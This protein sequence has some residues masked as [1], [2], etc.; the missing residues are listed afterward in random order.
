MFGFIKNASIKL[1]VLS[2]FTVVFAATSGLG[3]VSENR[4]GAVNAESVEIR[5][6]Y[7]PSTQML[8]KLAYTAMQFRQRE[9][10]QLLAEG[11]EAKATEAKKQAESLA[12]YEALM[13]AY[14]PTIGDG[15]ERRLVDSFSRKWRDYIAL[16]GKL[17][18]LEEAQDD[19][20]ATAL[21]FGEQRTL[22]NQYYEDL[23]ADL[24]F[25]E[26]MGS[27]AARRA[28][29]VYLTTRTIIWSALALAALLCVAAGWSII[30]GVSRPIGRMTEV[31][32]KLAAHDL[33]VA[34]E[35]RGGKNEIGRMAE[36]VQ[37]FKDTMIEGD[38]LAAE[39][40]AEQEAKMRRAA[41][42]D[43]MTR[44]FEEKVG[45]MVGALAA[46]ATEM[47]ASAGSMTTVAERT[48]EQSVSVAAA[49]EQTSAN[50]QT[51]ATATEEL[52]ASIQEISRQVATSARV[53][54]QA[55]KAAQETDATVQTL[56]NGAQKV[57]DVVKLIS[58]IASQTNLLALNATI[59]AARAGEAGKGFAV[60]ASEV[61]GLAQQT[62]KATE[63][64]TQQISG[65]QEATRQ[66][67]EAIRGIGGTIT[68]INEIASAIASAVEEQG[69]ATQEIAR[70]VQQAAQ[71]TEV[72][73][74]NIVNL[75]GSATDTGAAATQ[76]KGA[77]GELSQHSAQLKLEV[78]SFLAE[79][80]AA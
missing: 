30:A 4:L 72:V 57:G 49:S 2:A 17:R 64:I 8:G 22:F 9:A 37:V 38:R 75:K 42:V 5:T 67:V 31:M 45:H 1:Q 47:E 55:V 6:N 21:Y 52:S 14:E 48:N 43:A 20:A 19:V 29:Q 12:D 33:T 80:K 35:G 65:I 26:K 74:S 59:E 10:T 24:D 76:V 15:E 46:A 60:V 27:E 40:A 58:D 32:K 11:T 56:A 13:R 51:V 71:A 18:K 7:L 25:N 63:E 69:A 34:V 16:N 50:V 62:A 39:Q 36:A 78:D 66:A 61:K 70:N 73:N 77:A 3:L 54:E 68:E 79:V 41:S 44:A 23:R 28:E 53:S